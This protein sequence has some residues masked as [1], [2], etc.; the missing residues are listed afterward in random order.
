MNRQSSVEPSAKSPLPHKH[1]G[2][3]MSG[4]QFIWAELDDPMGGTGVACQLS[5]LSK[6][7]STPFTVHQENS[8][9][10]L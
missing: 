6:L 9:T 10:K 4:T 8:K 2:Y 3:Y 5:G 1:L 7:G